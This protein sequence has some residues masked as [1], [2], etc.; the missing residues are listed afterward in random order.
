MKYV[1]ADRINLRKRRLNPYQN[2]YSYE[3]TPHQPLP[4]SYLN[5]VV[6]REIN[7]ETE[8]GKYWDGIGGDR[9]VSNI[10]RLDKMLAP[11]SK[12]LLTEVSK[13]PSTN[14]LGSRVRRRRLAA[15]DFSKNSKFN[16]RC[17]RYFI[18]NLSISKKKNQNN[19]KN[20][21]DTW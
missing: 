11:T 15:P 10:A 9:W 12:I 21:S 5:Q 16:Y 19:N 18:Q 8:I 6:N 1:L 7:P 13:N 17:I 14:L 3:A 4:I 20:K 2:K